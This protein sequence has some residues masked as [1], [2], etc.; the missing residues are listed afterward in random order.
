MEF[1][2]LLVSQDHKVRLAYQDILVRKAVKD[3]RDKMAALVWMASLDHR[4]QRV[5]GE[6][7]AIGVNLDEMELVFQVHPDPLDNLDKLFIVILKIMMK[8]KEQGLR[9]G[10][11]FLVKQDSQAQW[12]RKVIEENLVHQAMPLREK[13]ENLDLFLDLMETHITLV[14][15]QAKRVRE[16]ILDQSDLLVQLDLLV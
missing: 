16:G 3:L 15:W 5:T 13:K 9:V 7:E 1:R 2:D 10:L 8:L 11:V 6:T 12:D 14:D 4:D